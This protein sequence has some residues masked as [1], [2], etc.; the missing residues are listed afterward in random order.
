[1]NT[2]KRFLASTLVLAGLFLASPLRAE[3]VYYLKDGSRAVIA[4]RLL[5]VYPP[6]S[7]RFFAPPG[8]YQ[9][10]DGRHTIVVTGRTVTVNRS[11]PRRDK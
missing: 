2:A 8:K 10:R 7:K 6:N 4:E 1:M 11:E 5:I 9:T 3:D